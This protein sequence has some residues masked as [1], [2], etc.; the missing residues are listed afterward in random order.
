MSRQ[1]TSLTESL[2]KKISKTIPLNSNGMPVTRKKYFDGVVEGLYFMVLVLRNS[3]LRSVWGYRQQKTKD[4]E[5]F[6]KKIGD[7]PEMNLADARVEASRLRTEAMNGSR[8]VIKRN[9]TSVLQASSVKLTL[10]EAANMW[11]DHA[12][13][14]HAYK[15]DIYV[16]KEKQRFTKNVLQFIGDRPLNDLALDD[17]VYAFRFCWDREATTSRALAT[18]RKVLI[19]AINRKICGIE[20]LSLVNY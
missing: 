19:Y 10:A 18:L 7:Y 1:A 4:Q 8:G 9:K 14:T 16:L 5:A 3:Q 20:K 17:V 15:K 13:K 11:F 6:D 12:R 2:V